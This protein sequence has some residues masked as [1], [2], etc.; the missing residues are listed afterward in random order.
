MLTISGKNMNLDDLNK[1]LT[2]ARQ[3]GF[4]FNQRK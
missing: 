1:K 2:N 3:N 4:V